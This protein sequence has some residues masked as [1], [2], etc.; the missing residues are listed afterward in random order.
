MRER[1]AAFISQISSAL[2]GLA[3]FFVLFDCFSHD[4]MTRFLYGSS[5]G[6]DALQDMGD[7]PLVVNLKRGQVWTPLWV[8][9][10]WLYGSWLLKLF[11]DGDDKM[12]FE[13]GSEVKRQI[14]RKML[15]HDED[16]NRDEEYS[17]YRTMREA[18]R[19]GDHL[20]RNY[21]AS[22]MYDHLKAGQLTT[23]ATLTYLAWRLSRH[24]D[25]QRRLQDELSGLPTNADGQLALAD[26]EACP[27]ME[28]VITETLRLH[29]AASG[30][31]ERIVPV[32]GRTY[33]GIYVPGGTTVIGPTLVLHQD[34]EVFANPLEWR[35][36]RWL[37]ADEAQRKMM[38][39]S[40]VPFGHGARVCIGQHLAMME[41][42]LLTAS[43]YHRFT[44][45]LGGTCT[46]YEMHQLGTLAAVPRGLR[47]ELYVTEGNL[48]VI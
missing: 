36:E 25:W 42:R 44:T 26:T 9:F 10:G 30:R 5:H 14:E 23:A 17:L 28:A 1:V 18:K 6:T 40:F 16:P 47:C 39:Y 41:I 12:T 4:V 38:E 33:S 24:P 20:S 19:D 48:A 15:E 34:P 11:V 13:Y 37:E 27:V 29:P 31:Q 35:P 3:D 7:R 21:M 2:N 22:E 45:T 32:G 46:D 43:I 8:N